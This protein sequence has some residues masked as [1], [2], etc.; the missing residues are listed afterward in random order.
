MTENVTV[1]IDCGLLSPHELA[2]QLRV[3][4]L[5]AEELRAQ[6]CEVKLELT[7]LD[8]KLLH[9]GVCSGLSEHISVCAMGSVGDYCFLL[10]AEAILDIRGNVGDCLGHSMTSGHVTVHGNAGRHVAA[11]AK[12]GFVAVLG[13]A[14]D[15]CATGLVGADVLIRSRA[16]DRAGW[17][18]QGGTLL[19][20][21]GAGDELGAG[22]T[23][24][25]IYV[26]GE[27]KSKSASVRMER[28]KEADSLRLSLLLARAGIKASGADFKVYRPKADKV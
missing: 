3:E 17:C 24:G 11:Y 12:G 21:N 4:R 2:A 19:L 28:F 18:M 27:V 5:K 15:G 16:G 26:R 14:G 20:G 9:S 22:M 6:N 1:K 8:A 13:Q 7:G 23:G 10:G 25:L